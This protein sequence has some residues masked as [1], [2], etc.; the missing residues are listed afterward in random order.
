MTGTELILRNIPGVGSVVF[1]VPVIPDD[2]PALVREGLARRKILYASDVC[3]CGAVMELPAR[4]TS[5]KPTAG[6]AKPATVRRLRI[7]HGN[8]CPA[9][10]EVL[11]PAVAADL[12]QRRRKG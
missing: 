11:A 2:A 1:V 10:D 12:Q 6:E 5:R 7:E 3:P 9:R 4:R 8:D